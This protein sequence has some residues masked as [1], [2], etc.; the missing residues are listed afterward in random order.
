MGEGLSIN[1]LVTF[2]GKYGAVQLLVLLVLLLLWE[3]MRGTTFALS[4]THVRTAYPTEVNR[5]S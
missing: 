3:G 2:F 1:K 4:N 5:I